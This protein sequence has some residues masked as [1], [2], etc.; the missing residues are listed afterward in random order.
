MKEIT[1]LGGTEE[2]NVIEYQCKHTHFLSQ[3]QQMIYPIIAHHQFQA[4]TYMD[5]W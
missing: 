2:L 1:G 3:R 4:F 5:H